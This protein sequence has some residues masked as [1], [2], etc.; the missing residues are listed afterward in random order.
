MGINQQTGQKIFPMLESELVYETYFSLCTTKFALLNNS[1][2]NKKYFVLF[3][4][5]PVAFI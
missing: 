1:Y 3:Q 4:F 5:Y 2:Q